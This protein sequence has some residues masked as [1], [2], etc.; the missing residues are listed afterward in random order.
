MREKKRVT[1]CKRE[2]LPV[3]VLLDD[4]HGLELLHAGAEDRARGE[5]SL[6]GAG[7]AVLLAAKDSAESTNASGSEVELAGDGCSADVEPVIVIRRKLLG[8][9]SLDVGSPF[10]GLEDTSGL[11]LLGVGLDEE[12]SGDILDGHAVALAVGDTHED[13]R[14]FFFGMREIVGNEVIGFLYFFLESNERNIL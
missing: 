5:G 13:F 10:G 12:V 8:D 9:T 6:A 7:V 3:L 14:H 1:I 4:L 11:E 2:N